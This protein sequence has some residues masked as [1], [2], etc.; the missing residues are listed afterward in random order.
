MARRP[1]VD[2]DLASSVSWALV[3]SVISLLARKERFLAFCDYRIPE[4]AV[5]SLTALSLF[6][7]NLQYH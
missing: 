2:G 1:I 3:I 6:S 7:V 4:I 5:L